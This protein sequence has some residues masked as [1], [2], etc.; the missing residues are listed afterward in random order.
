MKNFNHLKLPNLYI[1]GSGKSGTST[2]HELLNEHPDICM[3]T[4]KEPHFWT[5]LNFKKY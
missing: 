5:D 1:P 4:R 2:L 3:S